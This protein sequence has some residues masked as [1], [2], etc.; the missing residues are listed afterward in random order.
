MALARQGWG[1]YDQ[2]AA[3]GR[4]IEKNEAL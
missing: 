1:L 2:W 3:E 4:K